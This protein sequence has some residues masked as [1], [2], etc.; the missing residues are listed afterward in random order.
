[1]TKKLESLEAALRTLLGSR[2]F[3]LTEALGELT[4]VI[5]PAEY[6][7]VMTELRDNISTRF[8]ILLDLSFK[9]PILCSLW[10]M[11]WMRLTVLVLVI[12]VSEQFWIASFKKKRSWMLV[13]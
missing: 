7:A 8:E 12:S 3:A 5:A 11:F 13:S 10:I 4:L 2:E 6:V 1:M 9:G